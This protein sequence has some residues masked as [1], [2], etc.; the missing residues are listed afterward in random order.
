MHAK[1][2]S[3]KVFTF[4]LIS[5][6][7]LPSEGLRYQKKTG[8]RHKILKSPNNKMANADEDR[9]RVISGS[10]HGAKREHTHTFSSQ[11]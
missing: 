2:N 8:W 10:L 6:L 7:T 4:V 9:E 3:T 11:C 5:P 1:I